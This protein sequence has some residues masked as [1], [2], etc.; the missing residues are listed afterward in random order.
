[1]TINVHTC[2][3]KKSESLVSP[4][5]LTNKSKGWDGRIRNESWSKSSDKSSG[6]K[7][8]TRRPFPIDCM[9]LVISFLA[10]KAENK[11]QN[12][13]TRSLKG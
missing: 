9:P 12:I 1:M 6:F 4:D 5:V 8:P 10:K 11:Q 7:E 3:N 2:H 13:I